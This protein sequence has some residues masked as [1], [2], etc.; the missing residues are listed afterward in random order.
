MAHKGLTK[1]GRP[2]KV[3]QIV[4]DN[5]PLDVLPTYRNAVERHLRI[6]LDDPRDGKRVQSDYNA[7]MAVIG[8]D[9]SD[10]THYATRYV[11]STMS[12]RSDVIV[13]RLAD[14]VTTPSSIRMISIDREF[15]PSYEVLISTFW[16]RTGA[17]SLKQEVARVSNIGKGHARLHSKRPPDVTLGDIAEA[18]ERN[19]GLPIILDIKDRDALEL[20]GGIMA[21]WVKKLATAAR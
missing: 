5:I 15:D 10:P 1:V 2:D 6:A 21:D 4:V 3:F 7:F 9:V 12:K 11:L 13:H 18:Q 19:R 8:S 17:A 14:D 16:V 20:L